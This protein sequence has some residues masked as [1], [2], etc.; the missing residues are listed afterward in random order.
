MSQSAQLHAVNCF[1]FSVTSVCNMID[2]QKHLLLTKDFK[3]SNHKANNEDKGGGN[4]ITP[5]K[6]QLLDSIP[7]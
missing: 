1:Q 3:F 4:P 7:Y 2:F 5:G 6:P